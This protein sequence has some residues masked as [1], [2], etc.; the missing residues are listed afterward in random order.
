MNRVVEIRSYNL[1]AD[2][3]QEFERLF[4]ERA[5]PM[6]ERWGVDV[7]GF[8]RSM[9]DENTFYLMRCYTSEQDRQQSQDAFYG[10]DEWRQGPREAI[11][12]CI[13]TYATVV[14]ALDEETISG[15][16]RTYVVGIH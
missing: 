9:H 7:I 16:R 6:L 3:R 10:S 14:L 13:D 11:L 15:L 1:K 2:K 8:G 12:A 5:R 4:A